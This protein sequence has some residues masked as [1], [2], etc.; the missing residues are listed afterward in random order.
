M[1]PI[2][3]N[4]LC[5]VRVLY[6]HCSLY[7]IMIFFQFCGPRSDKYYKIYFPG[8]LST[9]AM[10]KIQVTDTNDNRPIFYPRIYN[11]SLREGGDSS[12]A[13]VPVVSVAATDPD[14]GR[15]GT[16]T[17]KTAAGNEAGLFRI[18]KNS[19]E[20]FVN[21]L[22]LLS[23]RSQPLHHLNISATDGGGLKSLQDAEVFI[24]VIDSAQKPPLFERPRYT[25]SVKEDV[26]RD[27]LVGG[28]KAAVRDSGEGILQFY[29]CFIVLFPRRPVIV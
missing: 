23:T 13:T 22:N 7:K 12:S 20:L 2:L 14:S 24:S 16:V 27:T 5:E 18:D 19:G 6:H 11:V 26:K 8:G 17:Y 21:R 28:V 1:V 3:R 15:F 10:I 9:T 4:V 25:Y 29:V